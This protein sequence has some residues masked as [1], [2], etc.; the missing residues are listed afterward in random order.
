[1]EKQK[2]IPKIEVSFNPSSNGESRMYVKDSKEVA[3]VFLDCW[4]HDTIELYEEFKVLYL[5]RKNGI[6]GIR[7]L[8]IGNQD[9]VIVNV[10]LLVSIGLL[11]N[12]SSVIIAHNHPSGVV[13][14]SI[15]DIEL[16]KKLEKALHLFDLKLIDHIILTK[17]NY[18]SFADE[19]KII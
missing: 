13:D 7:N 8:N 6:I 10:K 4:N 9:G 15:N 11:C 14:P 12:C 17:Y 16:T 3:S 19:G 2:Q 1:M 5:D 18:L